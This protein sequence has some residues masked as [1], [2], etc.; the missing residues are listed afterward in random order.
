MKF[1]DDDFFTWEDNLLD[2]IEN[3]PCDQCGKRELELIFLEE[4]IAKP[5]G[6]FSLS[7]VQMKVSAN[8]LKWPYLVCECGRV[9]RGS[10][11]V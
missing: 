5:M 6:T 4:M 8:L 7:G 10:V 9:C 2:S 3:L 1:G 11:E